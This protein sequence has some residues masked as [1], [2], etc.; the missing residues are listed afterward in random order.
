MIVNDDFPFSS[1]DGDLESNDNEKKYIPHPIMI[2]LMM[3]QK[4]RN[5]SSTQNTSAGKK[6]SRLQENNKVLWEWVERDRPQNYTNTDHVY[7]YCVDA[8]Y[9]MSKTNYNNKLKQNLNKMIILLLFL[10]PD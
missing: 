9:P 5:R 3:S 7:A 6:K 2:T 10:M 1:D 8:C 4:R